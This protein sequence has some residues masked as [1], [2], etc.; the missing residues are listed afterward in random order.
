[1]AVRLTVAPRTHVAHV[2]DIDVVKL[3]A[4]HNVRP[5]IHELIDQVVHIDVLCVRISSYYI[6]VL[7]CVLVLLRVVAGFVSELR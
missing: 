6:V 5:G 2:E 3:P 7:L 4:S 1:M